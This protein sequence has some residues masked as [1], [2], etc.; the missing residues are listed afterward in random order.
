MNNKPWTIICIAFVA[1][2]FFFVSL[3]VII[4]KR[5]PLLVKRKLRLGALLIS[6]S[7]ASVGTLTTCCYAPIEPNEIF[8]DQADINTGKITINLAENDTLTGR[9]ENREAS[10]FSYAVIDSGR[11]PV[12]TDNIVPLDGVFDEET[13]EFKF[14]LGQS[15]LLGIYDLCFYSTSKDSVKNYD[16]YDYLFTLRVIE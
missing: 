13:E 8:I 2:A 7:G 4:S 6:L 1:V 5:H 3:L 10:N 11:T 15:I 14:G 9:I 12:K 16:W